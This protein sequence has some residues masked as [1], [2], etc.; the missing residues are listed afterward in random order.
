MQETVSSGVVKHAKDASGESRISAACYF[1][2]GSFQV[3]KVHFESSEIGPIVVVQME[4]NFIAS[5]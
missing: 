3:P 4:L 2:S 5:F 1:H